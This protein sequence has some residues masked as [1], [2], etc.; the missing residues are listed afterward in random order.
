MTKSKLIVALLALGAVGLLVPAL[1][2]AA[3]TQLSAN[4]KG[5]EEVSGGD[6]NGRGEAFFSVK[7]PSK[8]KLCYSLSWEKI[9][10]PIA[11]HI[12]KGAEGVDGPIKV[13][14]FEDPNG[15]TASAAEGCVKISEKIAKKLRSTPE[16]FYA[17]VHNAEFP[18]GAIRGQLG[19]AL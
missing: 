16:R 5:N 18:A 19:R 3:A 12:H 13:T 6:S 4:L 14:L 9:E 11:A 15:L 8:R 17:N 7:K 1:S 2:A 10:P